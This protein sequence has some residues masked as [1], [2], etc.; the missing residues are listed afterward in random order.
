MY[1]RN[2]LLQWA[3]MHCIK[4][5]VC[6]QSIVDD[7]IAKFS[8][9]VDALKFG[10]PWEESFLTPLPEFKSSIHTNLI[11]DARDKG[12]QIMNK[13]GGEMF[14]NYCFP[15]VMYPVD[16]SMDLYHEEQ[17]GPVIPIASFRD[18]DEPLTAMANSDYGQQVLFGKDVKN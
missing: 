8:E 12:A 4:N 6:S 13:K 17:F 16:E 9:S 14:P 10:L 18:I 7:F 2:T 1:I 5:I 3:K 15:A 11:E